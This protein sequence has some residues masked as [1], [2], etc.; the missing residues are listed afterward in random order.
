MIIAITG[1]PGTGKSTLAKLLKAK[2][3]FVL[4]DKDFYKKLRKDLVIYYDKKLETNIIDIERWDKLVKKMKKKLI[5]QVIF[6]ESHMSHLLEVDFVIVLERDLK[7]LR[8]EYEKRKYNQQKIK[9]NLEAEIFKVCYFESIEKL[10]KRKVKK[11]KNPWLA[12]HF[13]IKKLKL[14]K[15]G[16]K[17]S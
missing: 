12:Y 10:G 15:S 3:F 14:P 9:D 6:I 4:S 7:E 16:K 11:F 8:K 5:N 17:I 13:L 1:T 2:G